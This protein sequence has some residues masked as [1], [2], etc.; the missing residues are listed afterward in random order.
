MVAFFI[1]SCWGLGKGS[2]YDKLPDSDPCGYIVIPQKGLAKV[3]L[4]WTF[5]TFKTSYSDTITTAETNAKNA[6][7]QKYGPIE[8]WDVSDVTCMYRM[9]KHSGYGMSVSP[10]NADISKWNV[11]RTRIDAPTGL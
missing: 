1:A 4:D 9:L 8:E 3:V 7:V 10:F 6:V 5:G 2:G 11:Q